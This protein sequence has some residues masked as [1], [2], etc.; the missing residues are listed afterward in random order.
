MTDTEN[1][2]LVANTLRGSHGAA[3]D[4]ISP[5][6]PALKKVGGWRMRLPAFC[7]CSL[8]TPQLH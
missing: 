5:D 4:D 3:S 6:K 7:S 8:H 2:S 1:D